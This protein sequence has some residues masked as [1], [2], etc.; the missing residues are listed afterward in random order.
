MSHSQFH[1]TGRAYLDMHGLIF[2]TSICY[3]QD[4]PGRKSASERAV[5]TREERR[6]G[7][8]RERRDDRE[9]ERA[10]EER[11]GRRREDRPD[12]E[13]KRV[14]EAQPSSSATPTERP[15]ISSLPAH[16]SPFFSLLSSPGST[17]TSFSQLRIPSRPC[18]RVAERRGELPAWGKNGRPS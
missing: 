4:Q 1:C 14:G 5:T 16:L 10:R 17:Q 18:H 6:E 3:W 8:R 9:R 2:E 7:E 11:R 12:G 15:P 13:E